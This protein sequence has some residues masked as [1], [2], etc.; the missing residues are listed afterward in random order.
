MKDSYN[1][2]MLTQTLALASL[3]DPAYF[4]KCVCEI[5]ANRE[6]LAEGLRKLSFDILPSETNFLF[7]RPPKNAKK[8]FEDL[9]NRNII[10]RYFPMERTRDYVRIT[11]G[12][13]AE[14]TALL[15][16]TEEIFSC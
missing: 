2:S 10:V 14:N 5:K 15:K 1:V 13:S 3:R 7:V 6:I 12:S 4:E 11:V 9:K 16:A 8:Y